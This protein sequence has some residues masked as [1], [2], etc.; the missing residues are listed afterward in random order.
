MPCFLLDTHVWLWWLESRRISVQAQQILDD[1]TSDLMVSVAS[2]W[3]LSIK[4]M[5]GRFR[6]PNNLLE[7]TLAS[8][9]GILP[10]RWEHARRTVFL[11]NHHGDPFDRL[12]VAQ[13]FEEDRV[14]ITRD[15]RIGEYGI[16]VVPA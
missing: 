3:E 5:K 4:E 10:I 16:P 9:F 12:I 8:G 2:V 6:A 7:C 1:V 13:A 15:E 11:P 14:V